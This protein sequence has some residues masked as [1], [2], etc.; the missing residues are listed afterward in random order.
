[1][2]ATIRSPSYYSRSDSKRPGP[3]GKPSGT[4]EPSWRFAEGF[5]MGEAAAT[6]GRVLWRCFP[7]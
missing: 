5:T 4:F 2:S 1:M 6:R 3:A 7:A